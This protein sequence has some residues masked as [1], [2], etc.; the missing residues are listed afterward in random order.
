[1]S[2]ATAA[3]SLIIRWRT[4]EHANSVS[5][6]KFLPLLRAA[7]AKAPDR[8]D[9]KLQLAKALFRTERMQETVDRLRTAVADNDAGPEIH[10]YLGRAALAIR[11][12]QLAFDALRLAAAKAYTPAF[13]Y[14][15]EALVRLNR[16]GEALEAGLQGLRLSVSDSQSLLVVTRALLDQGEVERLW[17]LCIDL[18]ARGARGG[19]FPAVMAFATATL[20]LDDELKALVDPPRW[21]SATRL[22]APD[23]F[24]QRLA[25]E[26]VTL[27]LPS[28]APSSKG[29]G[30]RTRSDRLQLAVRKQLS[31]KSPPR[32]PS[33]KAT[34]GVRT[35]TA[36]LERVGGP[37]VQ[38]LLARIRKAVEIYVAERQSFSDHQLIAQ[39]PESAYL[40]SWALTVHD[41]KYQDW[42]LH[43]IA[44]IS[45]VY[46]VEVPTLEPRDDDYPGAI[47]FGLFPFG[48]ED[49]KLSPYRWRLRP[50]PGLLLLFPS[51]YAHRT[52][53]TGVSDPRMSVAFDICPSEADPD[54]E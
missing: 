3:P 33:P 11:D 17:D 8:T 7:V 28:D 29:T 6:E 2:V 9:L 15:A 31:L 5:I 22:A 26:L 20:G 4:P 32:S 19:W 40:R 10:Y 47:E 48:G 24:N 42:H 27:Q 46:Y 39:R 49:E 52:W 41:D 51:Y 30:F 21:F 35:R 45:G 50:E 36:Q 54:V 23:D 1:M 34:A 12:D 38:D 18:R 13:G 44:W 53:P 16:P 25:N 14:L 43:Q 37:L